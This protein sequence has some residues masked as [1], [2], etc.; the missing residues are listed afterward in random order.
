MASK[1]FGKARPSGEP[2]SSTERKIRILLELI[3]N[4]SVRMS[5]LC[6]DYGASERSMVRDFQELRK[7]GARAGFKLSDKVENDRMTLKSFDARPTSLDQGGK[8]LRSLIRTAARA[9]GKPVEQELETLGGEEAERAFLRFI[10]PTLREGTEVANIFNTLQAAWKA[11][12]RVRFKYANKRDERRV[13]PYAVLQHSGRYYLLGRDLDAKDHG[14]RHFALDQIRT[15]ISRAGTFTPRD[16]PAD[17]KHD[18]ALGWIKTGKTSRIS[19][20]LS[21]KIAPSAT[22]RRWQ[23]AQTIEGRDDGS[24]VITFTVSDPDEVIRWAFGYASEALIV[25]PPDAV[26]RARELT[27][28]MCARYD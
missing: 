16:I 20:W 1:R 17:Y 26:K 24:A 27:H 2:S 14:W 28:G 10:F 5:E 25:A 8:A 11:N 15:P 19:V 7:I 12:A 21:P 3:R 13:E 4:K 18:D 23:R 9:L 6:D 22:S